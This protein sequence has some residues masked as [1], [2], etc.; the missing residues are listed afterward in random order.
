MRIGAQMQPRLAHPIPFALPRDHLAGEQAGDDVDGVGHAVALRLGVDTE[1]HRIRGQQARAKAKH[2]PAA[3]L[4]VK[5]H[6]AVG[7]HE[8]VVVGQRNDPVP[9]R[10]LRVRSAAVAMNNSGW[11]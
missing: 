6:D 1:H 10:M 2:R 7:H 9:S 5:L 3:R 4:V 8:G 11:P